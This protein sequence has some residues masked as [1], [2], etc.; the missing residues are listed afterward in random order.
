MNGNMG[1]I[2]AYV[3]LGVLVL[4]AALIV[5]MMVSLVHAEVADE[6]RRLIVGKACTWTL[7]A[8][9]GA[10]IIELMRTIAAQPNGEP[11][12]PFVSLAV[13]AILYAVFLGWFK[14]K[15]GG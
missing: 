1:V 12:S 13:T 15:Y 2:L 11:S 8:T 6:R 3:F 9:V 10:E 7:I 14:H 4:S 5:W